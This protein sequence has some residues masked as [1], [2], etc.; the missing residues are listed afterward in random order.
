[1]KK[2]HSIRLYNVMFPIWFFF[3]F[4]AVWLL[5]LPVN[6]A[7]DSLVLWLSARK[8]QLPERKALWKEH[9]LPVWG[10]GFLCDLIGAG[11]TFGLYL[12]LAEISSLNL[13]L[14]PGATLLSIPGTVLAGVLIYFL[15]R[16]LTFRK[17]TLDAGAIHA[18]C[19]HLAI[20]TAPYTM[21]IPLYG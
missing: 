4:P 11:L 1:M 18:L 19:L 3:F 6:F 9:I 5:I 16:K 10:I 12:P 14:F 8:Q 2:D 15:N 21:L 17:S 20:F 7:V 13:H